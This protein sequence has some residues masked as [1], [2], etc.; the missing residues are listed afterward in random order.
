MIF[1]ATK[2]REKGKSNVSQPKVGASKRDAKN[3]EKR[4][5]NISHRFRRTAQKKTAE[6]R[7]DNPNRA[8]TTSNGAG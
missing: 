2:I 3:A 5:K 4:Q 1:L 6:L 8:K 7:Q